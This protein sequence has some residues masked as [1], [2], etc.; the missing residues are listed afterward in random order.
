M[1]AINTALVAETRGDAYYNLGQFDDARACYEAALKRQ[2]GSAGVLAKVCLATIS[3]R[4]AERGLSR[5][6]GALRRTRSCGAHEGLILAL[7]F[8]NH[9]ENGAG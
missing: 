7:V 4:Q 5:L 6:Q 2:N 1:P 9:I 3:R 8:L